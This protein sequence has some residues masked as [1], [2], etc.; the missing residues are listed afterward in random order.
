MYLRIVNKGEIDL[1]ALFLLGASTK[2]GDDTKIGFFGSGNKYA[3][4]TLLRKKIEV[5]IFSGL[6]E[7][8]I[9][10]KQVHF[11]NETFEQIVLNNKL[12][13]F[14]TRMGPTWETWFA[15][16]EFVCNAMDEG[17]YSIDVVDPLTLAFLEEDKDFDKEVTT[18]NVT[19][20]LVE[21]TEEVEHF[22][23]HINNFIL[24]HEPVLTVSIQ[25]WNDSTKKTKV[26]FIENESDTE[27]A[28]YRK[29]VRCN[30]T[31]EPRS[32]FNYNFE[33]LKINESRV[34]DNLSEVYNGLGRA[35]A[36]CNDPLLIG[37]LF[38]VILDD[39]YYESGMYWGAVTTFSSAWE[40]AIGKRTVFK[41]SIV[42][43]LPADDTF[44]GVILPDSLTQMLG[45]YFPK[46]D[47]YGKD[48]V[49]AVY[50]GTPNDW[51]QIAKAV[52][53]VHE[54]GYPIMAC[55]L[56]TVKFHTER[57]VARYKDGNIYLSVDYLD[58]YDY[59]VA[60]LM[61]E[62][63]QHQGLHDGTRMFEQFL[64]ER[65]ITAHRAEI[66]LAK[67]KNVLYPE[68]VLEIT[69]NEEKENDAIES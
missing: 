2:E 62:A 21:L 19:T 49:D 10:T 59:L 64:M 30:Y 29:G 5:R 60:T 9:K 44:G 15:L 69:Q 68:P 12:T 6:K 4:A 3:L 40:K 53:E 11:G 23:T 34:F 18:K 22:Y 35:W 56:H 7:I 27:H 28:I 43:F 55:K 52:Q 31:R 32:L 38:G 57:T 26:N 20:I 67:I 37:Q 42:K 54:F 63:I 45:Q 48:G 66:S 16:R 46:M 25:R 39:N 14:T 65:L 61:E 13:S 51:P 33:H 1:N 58:K 36:Q 17:G 50:V 47:I 24:Q 41:E 8:K